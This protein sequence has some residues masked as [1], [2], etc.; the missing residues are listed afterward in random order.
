LLPNSPAIDAGDDVVVGP[1]LNLVNDQRGLARKVGRRMDIGAIEYDP[2]QGR[3][4][5]FVVNTLADPE[6]FNLR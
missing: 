5:V 3:G 4:E 6:L 2:T 1:P